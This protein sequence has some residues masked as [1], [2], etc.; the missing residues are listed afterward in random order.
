MFQSFALRTPHCI[1][2][3]LRIKKLRKKNPLYYVTRTQILLL[4]LLLYFYF[5]AL[6]NV[7]SNEKEMDVNFSSLVMITIHQATFHLNT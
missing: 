1:F 6:L 2:K 4:L 7:I 5:L 3:K